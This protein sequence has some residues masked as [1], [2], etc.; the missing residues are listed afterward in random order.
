M[1]RSS[2]VLKLG[3]AF[4]LA[5]VVGANRASA[6]QVVYTLDTGN[7]DV[8]GFPVPY[9]T[10]TVSTAGPNS[11]TATLTL[12][13]NQIGNIVYL[14]GAQGI[15][16]FNTNGAINALVAGNFSGSNAYTDSGF[17]AF[18][19]GPVTDGG[20]GTEDGFGSFNKTTDSFDG[21]QHSFSTLV[22][23]I[24]KTSGTWLNAAAV[25][26][27]NASGNTVAAHV[28]VTT[29]NANGT[30]TNTGTTG[31]ATGHV[32]PE[33]T[34]FAIAGLGALGFLGYGLRRRAK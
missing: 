17:G 20:A 6:D 10:V 7:S 28:F 27:P 13:N 19:P 16:G 15:L 26:T 25:L 2:L 23:T 1:S 22:V 8:S 33:P 11:S 31:Y 30:L 12:T 4:A 9:G 3:L 34:T 14:F 18:T 5:L 32:V 29:R 24:T 21:Y